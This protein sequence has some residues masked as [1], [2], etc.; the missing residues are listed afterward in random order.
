MPS[1]SFF[2]VLLS[3]CPESGASLSG[4]R[5][6]RLEDDILHLSVLPLERVQSSFGVGH[7]KSTQEARSQ[8][9]ERVADFRI[10]LSG[11]DFNDRLCQQVA[12]IG[13]AL[14]RYKLFQT[15]RAVYRSPAT[16]LASQRRGAARLRVK[17]AIILA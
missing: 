3:H 13:G 8:V 5:I 7:L 14:G 1:L 16:S 15:V 17:R 6:V 2:C 10:E 11:T 4:I 9:A 12:Q